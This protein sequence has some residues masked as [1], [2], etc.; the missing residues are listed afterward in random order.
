[1]HLNLS[2]RGAPTLNKEVERDEEE[3][4]EAAERG[5][6]YSRQF[7]DGTRTKVKDLRVLE[8]H[9]SGSTNRSRMSLY[10]RNQRLHIPEANTTYTVQYY[11]VRSKKKGEERWEI[12]EYLEM[13]EK[14]TRYQIS[15]NRSISMDIY[16]EMDNEFK[17]IHQ[18][19][20]GFAAYIYEWAQRRYRYDSLGFDKQQ[21]FSI[22]AQ[23]EMTE[24]AYKYGMFKWVKGFRNKNQI[25]KVRGRILTLLTNKEALR[26]DMLNFTICKEGYDTVMNKNCR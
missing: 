2:N 22:E 6:S 17:Q 26:E 25:Y 1:M 9:Y 16:N 23:I 10:L 11:L 18:K 14:I 7:A 19:L 5:E 8:I 3:A 15:T 20:D 12:V 4:K 21:K 13:P 24:L